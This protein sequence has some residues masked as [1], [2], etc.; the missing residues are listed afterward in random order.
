MTH[1]LFPENYRLQPPLHFKQSFND[2]QTRLKWLESC[3]PFTLNH[4]LQAPFSLGAWTYHKIQNKGESYYIRFHSPPFKSVQRVMTVWQWARV[5]IVDWQWWENETEKWNSDISH[6]MISFFL[7][8]LWHVT[9]SLVTN[10]PEMMCFLPLERAWSKKNPDG[11][12]IDSQYEDIALPF[13]YMVLL[14]R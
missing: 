1:T 4:F 3:V 5:N 6:Y 7:H 13:K 11:E 12:D 10:R 14:A 2:I 8:S 9:V